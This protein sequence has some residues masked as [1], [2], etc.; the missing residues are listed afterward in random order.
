MAD[1][2]V[3]VELPDGNV[4]QMPS[5]PSKD[6]LAKLQQIKSIAAQRSAAPPKAAPSKTQDTSADELAAQSASMRAPGG[7]G[8]NAGADALH[9][10]GK[11][12][13]GSREKVDNPEF[14][15]KAAVGA[16]VG[17]GL[18]LAARGL[19]ML[20]MEAGAMFPPAAPVL[21]PL[22]AALMAGG[23]IAKLMGI[24][25]AAG[26]AAGL[27]EGVNE[28]LGTS[29]ATSLGTEMLAG[30]GAEGLIKNA[31]RTGS[32]A[33]YAATGRPWLAIEKAMGRSPED[34]IAAATTL[35][36]KRAGSPTPGFTATAEKNAAR[37]SVK[38]DYAAQDPGFASALKQDP[39]L[40]ASDHYMGEMNRNVNIEMNAGN[41]FSESHEAQDFA[42]KIN[43]LEAKGYI[44]KADAKDLFKKI[45]TDRS[46]NPEVRKDYAT[47][48]F[49]LGRQW[50]GDLTKT[51][52][53][54]I[55]E[56]VAKQVRDSLLDSF[57]GWTQ[58]VGL[59][60]VERQ[61]AEAYGREK[62]A[63]TVDTMS[64]IVS[65]YDDPL[66]DDVR[67]LQTLVRTDPSSKKVIQDSIREHLANIP[68]DKIPSRV[69][70]LDK[71]LVE[72]KIIPE[73]ELAP[74]RQLGVEV[75]RALKTGRSPLE[76]SAMVNQYLRNA[77]RAGAVSTV[78]GEGGRD[79]E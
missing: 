1:A 79:K 51:G 62:R 10:V 25:G 2:M 5:N 27:T 69:V 44:S 11:Y 37:D 72:N 40:K 28:K 34:K 52:Q 47:D 75:K 73:Y 67:S 13:F 9:A 18:P 56:H 42:A 33:L 50:K 17:A 36:A 26:A 12:L 68:V 54:A 39:K 16:L 41:K 31:A 76:K 77:S 38:A 58:R 70:A 35:Q 46:T 48:M 74:L 49:N 78:A 19:G 8:P 3:D 22:G 15:K 65:H 53:S 59:G 71:M 45:S 21:E 20:S 57:N 23:T 61:Y 43:V 4:I 14:G 32:T 60:R 64:R 24:G 55:D 30:M 6:D 63:E 7:L 29:R 66:K